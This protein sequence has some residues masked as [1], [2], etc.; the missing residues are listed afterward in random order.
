MTYF[1]QLGKFK[2]AKTSFVFEQ[3]ARVL[4]SI[5]VLLIMLALILFPDKFMVSFKSGLLLFATAV[6]PA[7]F[8]FM[9]LTK[10]LTDLGVVDKIAQFFNKPFAKLFK[11]PGLAFYVLMLSMLCG[12]PVGA[13]V[14]SDLCEKGAISRE[15]ANNMIPF[16]TSCGPLFVVGSVGVGMFANKKLGF[17]VFG[18]C[19][20]AAILTCFVFGIF[21]KKPQKLSASSAAKPTAFNEMLSKSMTD[22]CFSILLVGGYIA[23]FYL[24]I[25]I[26]MQFGI[27]LPF[28]AATNWLFG[29]FKIDKSYTKGTVAGIF[30]MTRGCFEISKTAGSKSLVF[31]CAIISFSGIS[32]IMQ[33]LCFLTKA[34]LS[35]GKFLLV[36]FVQ[37]VFAILI[38]MLFCVF[39]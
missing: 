2:Q 5:V 19:I 16:C 30:E 1:T 3:I 25:D 31:L 4:L 11:V 27:L 9:F 20:L 10:L 26:L 21:A 13:K 34:K 37:S 33:S 15:E 7:L 6:L 39:L 14:L 17:A 35:G 36:K 24:L 8:P 22:S 32:I 23:L 18:I 38:A 29:L 28:E 12:Y